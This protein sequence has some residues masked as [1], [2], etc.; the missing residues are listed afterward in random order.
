MIFCGWPCWMALLSLMAG[1]RSP[2]DYQAP[3]IDLAAV[4]SADRQSFS[5][6]PT[7]PLTLGD[8]INRAWNTN[9]SIAV[10]N[11]AFDVAVERKKV[12]GDRIE[13]ELR[14][15]Y[16]EG[17]SDSIENRQDVAPGTGMR[18]TST[19][20]S[21]NTPSVGLRFFPSHPWV[22]NARESAGV[23]NANAARLDVQAA[24]WAVAMQVSRLF[25]DIRYQN[26]DAAILDQLVA[27]QDD[28]LR[29]FRE[30]GQAV[31]TPEVLNVM[32]RRLQA[33]AAR[34]RVRRNLRENRRL[35]AW[36]VKLPVERIVLAD[37]KDPHVLV[38]LKP[39]TVEELQRKTLL[40]R[41]DLAA[42][43]W[44]SLAAKAGCDEVKAERIP[45]FS[46]VQASYASGEQSQFAS[47]HDSLSRKTTDS[48][49]WRVDAGITLP[50]FSWSNHA[51]ALRQA[52]YRLADTAFREA[53][54]S[55]EDSIQ[56]NLEAM[57]S[58][59]ELKV[60]YEAQSGP[61][62]R[63]FEATRQSLEKETGVSP[64]QMIALREQ[65][66]NLR[67]FEL[68]QD[69]EYQKGVLALE[70]AIGTWLAPVEAR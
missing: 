30:R 58:L 63:E 41:A 40:Y 50:L 49:E 67:R 59:R 19:D 64:D 28:N 47:D 14:L 31:T 8:A 7:G 61:V 66:L 53:I 60:Q 26:Q 35:L 69:Y 70:E 65:Q 15:S 51:L 24:K 36:R 44:R 2:V 43:Q 23:A 57:Q 56:E 25:T 11:A 37:Q 16:A 22:C 4:V 46:F 54:R 55:V 5:A 17:T 18:Y 6:Y 9:G 45:W 29:L 21:D 20:G 38:N 33:L 1:C 32:Q 48:E 68:E 34:D 10:L 3:D 52:E 27:V 42:L 62:L 12:A 13:P 39:L